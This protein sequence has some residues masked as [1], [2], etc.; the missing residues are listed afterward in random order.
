MV[1]ALLITF[2]IIR[3]FLPYKVLFLAD[4]VF[5]TASSAYLFATPR[6]IDDVFGVIA[7]L[8]AISSAKKWTKLNGSTSNRARQKKN[9]G[10]NTGI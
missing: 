1:L 10:T 4:S 9:S 8:I 2:I 5:F 3:M 6:A 7:L